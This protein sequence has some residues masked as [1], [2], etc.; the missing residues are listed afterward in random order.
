[1]PDLV[2][3]R[4]LWNLRDVFGRLGRLGRFLEA[5]QLHVEHQ[6]A[7]RRAHAACGSLGASSP[8]ARLARNPEP[9]LLAS[10]HHLHAFGPT[11]D[12]AVEWKL[13]GLSAHHRAIEHAPGGGPAGVVDRHD[14]CGSRFL[15][16][17]AR[18]Q[19]GPGESRL[20]LLRVLGRRGYIGGRW[21]RAGLRRLEPRPFACRLLSRRLRLFRPALRL[22]R[23]ARPPRVRV[24]CSCRRS[25]R[26][27]APR[28]KEGSRH[29]SWGLGSRLRA[30]CLLL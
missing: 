28:S 30:R 14:V 5:D 13:R 25:T 22:P 6:G 2:F 8:Y 17:G 16:A 15:V 12:D 21:E 24:R 9:A 20:A 23:R 29:F 26:R 3:F 10:N 1:M 19:D 7:A 27:R 4:V 18:L 11:L